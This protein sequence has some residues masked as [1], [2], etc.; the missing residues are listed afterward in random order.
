MDAMAPALTEAATTEVRR[1]KLA[2]SVPDPALEAPATAAAASDRRL[3][4]YSSNI[5]AVRKRLG[6]LCKKP[7]RLDG[8]ITHIVQAPGSGEFTD[9]EPGELLPLYQVSANSKHLIVKGRVFGKLGQA[10]LHLGQKIMKTFEQNSVGKQKNGVAK[11]QQTIRKANSDLSTRPLNGKKTGNGDQSALKNVCNSGCLDPI[12]STALDVHEL[13]KLSSTHNNIITSKLPIL[14]DSDVPVLNGKTRF[15]Q[16]KYNNGAIYN[17]ADSRAALLAENSS[18]SSEH[19]A[20]RPDPLAF[21]NVSGADAKIDPPNPNPGECPMASRVLSSVHKLAVLE[22]RARRLSKHLRLIQAEQ[23]ESHVRQQLGGLVESLATRRSQD[24]FNRG[25]SQACLQN[26]VSVSSAACKRLDVTSSPLCLRS[27]RL[28]SSP[29][30]RGR[31]LVFEQL[32]REELERVS[33]S[34]DANLRHVERALD[35]DATESSSGGETDV[36]EERMPRLHV[37]RRRTSIQTSAGWRWAEERAMVASRWTWLTAQVSD[38]EYRIRQHNELYRQIRTNK[39]AVMLGE[40]QA[41]VDL[42]QRLGAAGSLLK[43]PLRKST[44]AEMSPC[45]PAVLLSNIHKQSSQ[46]TQTLGGLISPLSSISP[47]SPAHSNPSMPQL[48]G[49]VPGPENGGCADSSTEGSDVDESDGCAAIMQSPPLS[50]PDNT[51]VAARTRPLRDF[52]KRRTLRVGN[53]YFLSRK[54]Q[55]PLTTPC[56]CEPP[57]ACIVCASKVV[58]HQPLDQ[59][60]M[61]VPERVAL[62]RASFHPVLSFPHEIPLQERFGGLLKQ[63]EWQTRLVPKAKANTLRKFCTPNKWG[64]SGGLLERK[65][66]QKLDT[67]QLPSERFEWSSLFLEKSMRQYLVRADLDHSL[68]EPSDTEGGD[69]C[70]PNRKRRRSGTV[71]VPS[72][73]SR[74]LRSCSFTVGDCP[75]GVLGTPIRHTQTPTLCETPTTAL[76]TSSQ[77]STPTPSTS[78][79]N[80]VRRRRGESSYDINNIVIPLSMAA[81]AR[82]EKIQYKEIL[83]PGWQELE[84]VTNLQEVN[85][86]EGEVEDLSDEAFAIRHA[87]CEQ[88]EK[89]RWCVWSPAIQRRTRSFHKSVSD[90]RATPP[91]PSPDTSMSGGGGEQLS[92]T[93]PP[94]QQ[95]TTDRSLRDS[96]CESTRSSTPDMNAEEIFVVVQ[97]WERRTFPLREEE[98]AALAG[99][100]EWSSA[101]G[102]D[103]SSPLDVVTPLNPDSPIPSR[104]NTDSSIWQ[105]LTTG[106]LAQGIEKRVHS[107]S[108][109]ECTQGKRNLRSTVS[110][111]ANTSSSVQNSEMHAH[112]TTSSVPPDPPVD[113]SNDVQRWSS[114]DYAHAETPP[115]E[116]C[117][118]NGSSQGLGRTRAGTM[119]RYSAMLRTARRTNSL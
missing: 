101:D 76:G 64:A 22:Q 73:K 109:V 43:G 115:G 88:L 14:R 6:C 71:L 104:N 17:V 49:T 39:G 54:A 103:P 20:C 79:Q 50:P 7:V 38:L 58:T 90:G 116:K 12:S 102:Q 69:S 99:G 2:P 85:V 68:L 108:D 100:D 34:L 118:S 56:G 1:L 11:Q 89:A 15:E 84:P 26:G 74:S 5:P 72:K 93:E 33:Q 29:L 81:P 36:E 94:I 31:N 80:A 35:S 91:P 23:T 19:F 21:V 53:A 40:P 55:R 24:S 48:N 61:T 107:A 63:P 87:K 83:T 62:L 32:P 86:E 57:L 60:T 59:D 110:R 105:Q 66:R 8:G 27:Q 113:A 16:K 13:Q 96:L 18:T 4:S 92:Y 106:S 25:Q 37:R 82:V 112:H 30:E 117:N 70:S 28:H 51:C 65:L 75:D 42:M 52:R 111:L 44:R 77:T 67:G 114:C 97:P 119:T 95:R 9:T 47:G 41:P 10:S 46:L 78:A 45:S 98:E 3:N